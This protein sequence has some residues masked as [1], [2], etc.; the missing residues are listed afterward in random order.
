MGEQMSMGARNFK[1]ENDDMKTTKCH[2]CKGKGHV[3]VTGKIKSKCAYCE[4]TGL[5]YGTFK[6]CPHLW[7]YGTR[8]TIQDGRA[9]TLNFKRCTICN[10]EEIIHERRK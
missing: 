8:D 7:D 4:G 1:E 3:E 6:K 9:K 10:V 5:R 2:N